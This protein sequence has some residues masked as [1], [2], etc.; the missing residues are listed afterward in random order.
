LLGCDCFLQ[1]ITFQFFLIKEDLPLLHAGYDIYYE[2][3]IISNAKEAIISTCSRFDTDEYINDRAKI[4]RELYFGVKRHLGNIIAI[5]T[6]L[7]CFPRWFVLYSKLYKKL[8]QM[9]GA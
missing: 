8:S 3:I 2:P 5:R 9:S 4:W 6:N 1:T 7:I